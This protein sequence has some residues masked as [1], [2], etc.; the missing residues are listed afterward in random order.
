MGQFLP[1]IQGKSA[2]NQKTTLHNFMGVKDS[3]RLVLLRGTYVIRTR[4]M[5]TF[6]INV[7]I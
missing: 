3:K 1:P 7:L 5:Y 4:K 2:T 6:Y